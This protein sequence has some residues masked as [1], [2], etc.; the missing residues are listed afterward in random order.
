MGSG[1]PTLSLASQRRAG[2]TAAPSQESSGI[3]R[4]SAKFTPVDLHPYFNAGPADF[5]PRDKSLAALRLGA[6]ADDPLLVCGIT[7]F[8]G[9]QHPLRYERLTLYRLTLPDSSGEWS[10]DV[11]LGVIARSY[12]LGKFEPKEWLAAP[13]AG[14]GSRRQPGDRRHFYVELT[15]SS[16]RLYCCGT[17]AA[18]ANSP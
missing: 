11:D 18:S 3:R 16:D 2:P 14:L 4:I 1:V 9:R 10:V 7:L 15:A 13:D 8:H 17:G 12:G 5:G 6:A